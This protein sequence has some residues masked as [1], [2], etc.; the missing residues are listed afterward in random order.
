MTTITK[1]R[2]AEIIDLLADKT[3]SFGCI[4]QY[5]DGEKR[6][7]VEKCANRMSGH[8]RC[9]SLNPTT[10][11][12]FKNNVGVYVDD[13]HWHESSVKVL[14]HPIHLHD[15]LDKIYQ[16]KDMGAWQHAL[17]CTLDLWSKCGIKKSLQEIA[18][19]DSPESQELFSCLDTLIS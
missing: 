9:L 19:I 3:L 8:Y 6:Y 13:I 5:A 4:L 10:F 2:I 7:F 18:E 17:N 12:D 15:V 1:D 14:G 11:V 16:I